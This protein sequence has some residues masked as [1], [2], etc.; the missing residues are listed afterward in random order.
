MTPKLKEAYAQRMN[1]QLKTK[2]L[3]LSPDKQTSILIALDS[4][5]QAI[6]QETFKLLLSLINSQAEDK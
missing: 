1:P 4:F 6:E 5:H 3:S 2:F